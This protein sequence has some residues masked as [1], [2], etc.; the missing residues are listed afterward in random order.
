MTHVHYSFPLSRP[1]PSLSTRMQDEG[2][3][4]PLPSG[5]LRSGFVCGTILSCIPPCSVPC[6]SGSLNFRHETTTSRTSCEFGLQ[7]E[8]RLVGGRASRIT[9]FRCNVDVYSTSLL[10]TRVGMRPSSRTSVPREPL[11]ECCRCSGSR[12]CPAWLSPAAKYFSAQR[13]A[14]ECIYGVGFA[15]EAVGDGSS[16]R[17]SSFS[18]SGVSCTIPPIIQDVRLAHGHLM[19]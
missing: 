2:P 9:S 16:P 8:C 6:E 4:L 7:S 3:N 11:S 13:G 12:G 18:M 1:P 17:V 14:H 5:L 19:Q 10:I 15:C